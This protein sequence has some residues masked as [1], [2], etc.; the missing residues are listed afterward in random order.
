MAQLE[1]HF[2]KKIIEGSV[3][4]MRLFQLFKDSISSEIPLSNFRKLFSK[5]DKMD[6]Y[7]MKK[8]EKD[9]GMAYFM[10]CRNP[11]KKRDVYMRLGLGIIEKERS[12]SN[13]PKTLI[14][15]VLI[16]FR[17]RNPWKKIYMV[18]IIMN[19]IIYSATC[20]YW[21]YSYPSPILE[22]PNSINALKT[23][24]IKMF[25]LNEVRKDVVSFPFIVTEIQKVKKK[26]S[27]NESNNTYIQYFVSKIG[28]E[29]CDMGLLSIVPISFKNI[30]IGIIRKYKMDFMRLLFH[31]MDKRVMPTLREYRPARS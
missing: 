14:M 30:G 1:Y 9:I 23:R 2:V 22:K 3:F 21:K 15:K 28:A 17:L 7:I 24:I 31:I 16:G 11:N 26:F 4:E 6:L 29:E 12:S 19:P 5:Y 20:R 13:F 18:A 25:D 27:S 10:S 8:N